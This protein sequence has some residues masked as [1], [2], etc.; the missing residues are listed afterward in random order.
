MNRRIL[1]AADKPFII[2]LGMILVFGLVI[3]SSAGYA[4]STDPFLYLKKQLMWVLVGIVVVIVM[5]NIDFGQIGRFSKFWYLATIAVLILVLVFGK[6]VRGTQ[7]WIGI[8]GQS[9]QIAELSKIMLILGFADFLNKRQGM[10]DS[11]TDLL[12]CFLYVGVPFLLVLMQRDLGTALVFLAIMFGMMFVAGANPRL[13]VGLV[14]AGA[15]IVGSALYLHNHYGMWLPLEDYQ[16]KR[17]TVFVDPYNDGMG[18]RGAGWNTIQS[19]VAVGSGGLFGKGLFHG[20]QSQL[21]FLPEQ[22]TDFIFAVVGE[23]LGFLGAGLLLLMFAIFLYRGVDI[24]YNAK[25]LYSSLVGIGIISMW[26]FHI[27]ENVGMSLALMP[28]TGIPLP[29]VSYGGSFMIASMIGV[30]LLLNISIKS[31]KR[32]FD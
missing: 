30:G 12:P 22:H 2:S 31:N 6:E 16:V 4:A 3:L 11:I 7:G 25:D 21:N 8:G 28:I 27:F 19:L 1:K 14:I 26:I 24:A 29:F 20:T 13:L 23:E 5:L 10:L 32:L 17:L 15:F 9:F 18:G